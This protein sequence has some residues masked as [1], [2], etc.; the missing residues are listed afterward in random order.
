VNPAC[1]NATLRSAALRYALRQ[2]IGARCA[3][4]FF[5]RFLSSDVLRL[6]KFKQSKAQCSHSKTPREP[7]IVSASWPHAIRPILSCVDVVAV[8]NGRVAH[9]SSWS[10]G[11]RH[12][13]NQLSSK[14]VYLSA[15]AHCGFRFLALRGC[16]V[17]TRFTMRRIAKI[18]FF[19]I[20]SSEI[21]KLPHVT[22]GAGFGYD[23]RSP[24]R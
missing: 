12:I 11:L 18:L 21:L 17:G 5:A 23:Q 19:P 9:S 7:P 24:V 13:G 16:L 2:N 22:G 14:H 20:G 4:S 15:Q 8:R 10:I 3:R 1:L 6:A